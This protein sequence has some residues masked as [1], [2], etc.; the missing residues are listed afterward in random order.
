VILGQPVTL[1]V[2]AVGRTTLNYRWRKDGHW[3]H[4]DEHVSGAMT[5]TLTI[6]AVTAADAGVYDVVVSSLCGTVTSPAAT[7]VV[8]PAAPPGS[9][10]R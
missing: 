8:P 5:A 1:T 10:K 3:L 6:A 9:I 4:D 2:S 7:L